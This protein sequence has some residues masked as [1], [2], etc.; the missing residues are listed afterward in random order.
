[1][2]KPHRK[3]SKA[4]GELLLRQNRGDA[5]KY[6]DDDAQFRPFYPHWSELI[7][8]GELQERTPVKVHDVKKLGLAGKR[9]FDELPPQY[10]D[11]AKFVTDELTENT[12]LRYPDGQLMALFLKNVIPV[13]IRNAALEGLQAMIFDDPER[14]ETKNAIAFNGPNAKVR[15]G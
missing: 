5:G 1:M 4:V 8:R 2:K 9:S 12:I 11:P 7:K 6:L 13:E 14:A 3:K 15:A 10:V